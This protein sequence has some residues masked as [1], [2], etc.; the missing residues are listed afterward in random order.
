MNLDNTLLA[1]KEK[2]VKKPKVL[3]IH[4]AGTAVC[5]LLQ[6]PACNGNEWI[7]VFFLAESSAPPRMPLLWGLWVCSVLSVP[8]EQDVSVSELF[9]RLIQ[10]PQVHRLQ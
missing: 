3:L 2:A 1:I 7:M 5:G 10:G 9:Y 4:R 8:W 6:D